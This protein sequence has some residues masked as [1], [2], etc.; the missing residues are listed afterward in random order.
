MQIYNSYITNRKDEWNDI[1]SYQKNRDYIAPI[2]KIT[3]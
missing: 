1:I 3:T 2:D